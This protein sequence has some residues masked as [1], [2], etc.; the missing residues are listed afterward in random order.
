M[1]QDVDRNQSCLHGYDAAGV[2][3]ALGSQWYNRA[4]SHYDPCL[5]PW[6]IF[7]SECGMNC[8]SIFLNKC[9]IRFVSYQISQM[10]NLGIF[11]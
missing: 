7:L 1:E 10:L 2:V 9:D 11:S 4:I 8:H 3:E 5:L 6:T